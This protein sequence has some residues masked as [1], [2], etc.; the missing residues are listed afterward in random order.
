M[1]TVLLIFAIAV[2]MQILLVAAFAAGVWFE[3]RFG[4]PKRDLP[5]MMVKTKAGDRLHLEGCGYVRKKC[6]DDLVFWQI[7]DICMESPR[8]KE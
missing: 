8:K 2:L 3:R 6:E 5:K 1:E 7:C 4:Q